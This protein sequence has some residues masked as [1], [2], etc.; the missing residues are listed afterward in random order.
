MK[1]MKTMKTNGAPATLGAMFGRVLSVASSNKTTMTRLAALSM[2]ERGPSNITALAGMLCQSPAAATGLVDRLE[3]DGL[4]VR[5]RD[6]MGDRREILLRLTPQGQE[7]ITA[8][9]SAMSGEE[10]AV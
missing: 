9:L 1:T 6:P 4:L 5:Y 2:L 8:L 7:L 3:S 10:V